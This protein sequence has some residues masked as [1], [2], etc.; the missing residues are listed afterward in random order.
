MASLLLPAEA[1]PLSGHLTH[2]PLQL[3]PS[4]ERCWFL[5]ETQDP[6]LY[7]VILPHWKSILIMSEGKK[8][9][10]RPMVSFISLDTWSTHYI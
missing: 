5:H 10:H 9:L 6:R 8:W 3:V 4:F 2:N 7:K 1:Q